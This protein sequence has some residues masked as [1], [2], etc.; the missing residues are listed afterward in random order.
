MV[1]R[2]GK[3]PRAMTRRLASG[4]VGSSSRSDASPWRSG[5][6]W[7]V[8]GPQSGTCRPGQGLPPGGRLVAAGLQVRPTPCKAGLA[9]VR[10]AAKFPAGQGYETQKKKS[11][12]MFKFFLEKRDNINCMSPNKFEQKW[13][14]GFVVAR[15]SP[16]VVE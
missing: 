3:E 7:G 1:I 10:Q 14:K 6:G 8:H 11:G 2:R 16:S 4:V 13:Q 12:N 9:R 15:C 5:G